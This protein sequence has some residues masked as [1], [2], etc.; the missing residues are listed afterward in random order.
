MTLVDRLLAL[1][2]RLEGQS[3]T[4]HCL[5]EKILLLNKVIEMAKRDVRGKFTCVDCLLWERNPTE[6]CDDDDTAWG[7]CRLNNEFIETVEGDWCYAGLKVTEAEWQT[8]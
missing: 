2:D 4:R 6:D 5:F 8:E 3:S 7:R 1:K